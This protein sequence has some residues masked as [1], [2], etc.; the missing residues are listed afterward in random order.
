MPLSPFSCWQESSSGTS[1]TRPSTGTTTSATPATSLHHGESMGDHQ[2]AGGGG[3]VSVRL[4]QAYADADA[5]AQWD[6][7]AE[8]GQLHGPLRLGAPGRLRLQTG[9]RPPFQV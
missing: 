5:L 9:P 3:L 1:M 4:G 6:S 8:S 7:E 2:H